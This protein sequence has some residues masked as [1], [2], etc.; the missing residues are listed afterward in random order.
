MVWGILESSR[1]VKEMG[2][3]DVMVWNKQ[4]S[5]RGVRYRGV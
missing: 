5:S 1:G 4:E 2:V 3:Y